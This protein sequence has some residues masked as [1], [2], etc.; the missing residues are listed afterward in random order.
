MNEDAFRVMEYA[1]H[2]FQCSQI[3]MAIALEDQGKDNEDLLRAMSGLQ[4]GMGAGK[5]CGVL[6]GGCCVLGLVAGWGKPDSTPD[7]R[8]TTMLTDFVEWFECE[9]RQRYG[10]IECASIVGDD[11]RNR[12]TRCP[13]IVLES[14]ERLK[15]ILAEHDYELERKPKE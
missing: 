5:T 11:Q 12:V 7:E 14:L 15:Q 3:L 13:G 8:L 10:S 9:Y 4:A 6:T 2:G 1:S